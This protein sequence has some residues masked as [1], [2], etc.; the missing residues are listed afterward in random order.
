MTNNL[1]GSVKLGSLQPSGGG[2]T[3]IR[4]DSGGQSRKVVAGKENIS[5][6][7]SEKRDNNVNRK[8]FM[9]L[10]PLL[11]Q[12]NMGSGRNNT[13][14]LKKIADQMKIS[15]N[16]HLEGLLNTTHMECCEWHMYLQHN[17]AQA[18]RLYGAT[19]AFLKAGAPSH[20]RGPAQPSF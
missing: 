3:G 20:M 12:K 18:G 4:M 2:T 19:G 1:D 5:S 13:D 11:I 15:K 14:D 7:P 10:K 17:R 6:Q 9:D 8:T 16:D